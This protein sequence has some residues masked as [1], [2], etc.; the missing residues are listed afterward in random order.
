MSSDPP[1]TP[2]T[3]PPIRVAS[4]DNDTDRL[5]S[6][7]AAE[8]KIVVLVEANEVVVEIVVDN[9]VVVSLVVVDDSKKLA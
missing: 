8:S 1:T 5:V 7:T 2:P 4:I 3:T 9:I 6:G